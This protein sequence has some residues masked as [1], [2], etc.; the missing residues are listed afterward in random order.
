MERAGCEE[1]DKCCVCAPLKTGF[2]ILAVWGL[3]SVAYKAYNIISIGINPYDKYDYPTYK[4]YLNIEMYCII[5][6]MVIT[7][8]LYA[9]WL[10]K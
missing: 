9:I 4:L 3:I 1:A 6:F 8:G 10:I 5:G 2:V 7:V